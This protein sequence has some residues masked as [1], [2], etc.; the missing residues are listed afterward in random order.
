ML[1][2]KASRMP[3][4]YLLLARGPDTTLTLTCRKVFLRAFLT[5]AI[6]ALLYMAHH[7]YN[8][9]PILASHEFG[10]ALHITETIPAKDTPQLSKSHLTI[11]T[12]GSCQLLNYFLLGPRYS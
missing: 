6:L 8:R 5:R 10:M 7:Y 12:L 4:G 1:S 3:T 11:L 9:I 2:M